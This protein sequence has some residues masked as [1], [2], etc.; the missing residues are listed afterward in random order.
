MGGLSESEAAAKLAE[1][2]FTG[3]RTV[4]DGETVTDQTPLGGAIVPASAEV[5]LYMGAE[6]STE[7]CTVPDVVGLTPAKANTALVN[8]GLILKITGASGDGNI[9]AISQS[10]EPGT[11]VEAGTVVTVQMGQTST[12]A[13]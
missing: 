10:L 11:Q 2:G 5:I 6:K 8:A 3:Y 9:K 12:T 13:D 1:Y 7:L 4:G